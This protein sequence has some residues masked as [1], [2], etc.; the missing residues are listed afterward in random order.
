MKKNKIVSCGLEPQK[1]YIAC[2]MTKYSIFL[3]KNSTVEYD[4]NLFCFIHDII[5]KILKTLKVVLHCLKV[6]RDDN[7]YVDF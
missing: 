5:T 4:S 7:C 2:D 6:A 3:I 1:S